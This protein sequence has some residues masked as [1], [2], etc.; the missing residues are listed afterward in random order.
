MGT[1]QRIRPVL[2]ATGILFLGLL[3]TT[4]FDILLVF[5]QPRFYSNA[6]FIVTFGVGGVF[7]A[8]FAYMKGIERS[9]QKDEMARWSLVG[10]LVIAGILLYFVI[11]RLEGGEYAFPFRAYGISIALTSL[12][13]V[14]GKVD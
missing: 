4:L 5:T 10:L 2:T 9:E 12:I 8:V 6:L 14:R 11:A 7:A 1:W 13:F 3:V